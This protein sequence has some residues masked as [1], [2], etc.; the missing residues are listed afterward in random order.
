MGDGSST[1]PMPEPEPAPLPAPPAGM[2]P[3]PLP[4]R[5]LGFTLLAANTNEVIPGYD[6]LAEGATIDL[7]ALP[8]RNLNIQANVDGVAVKVV[9]DYDDRQ[10]DS[11]DFAAPWT[12][13]SE[14]SV[15]GLTPTV[16]AH[17]VSATPFDTAEPALPGLGLTV[18]FTVV[19]SGDGYALRT[20]ALPTAA[21]RAMPAAEPS[22][23]EELENAAA[24]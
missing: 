1:F 24:A 15:K 6:V 8:T 14:T 18:R 3:A 4:P 17:A 20:L 22:V 12:L 16:G 9:I 5:V 19:D 10:A 13:R 2:I 21:V 11:I 23:M 7:A